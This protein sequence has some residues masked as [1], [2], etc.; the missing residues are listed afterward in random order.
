MSRRVIPPKDSRG[1]FVRPEYRARG[2][3]PDYFDPV[4]RWEDIGPKI[5]VIRRYQGLSIRH[6]A[7]LAGLHH[8][9]V[10]HYERSLKCIGTRSFLR[11]CTALNV[12]LGFRARRE[13]IPTE[14]MFRGEVQPGPS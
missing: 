7:D 13:T 11:V 4:R 8:S 14:D 1:L 6:L 9:T 2:L 5:R 12:D 10:S 3:L